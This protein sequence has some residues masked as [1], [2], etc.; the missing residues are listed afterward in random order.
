MYKSRLKQKAAFILDAKFPAKL[1]NFLFLIVTIKNQTSSYKMTSEQAKGRIRELTDKINH[2]NQQYY[3]NHIS[4]ISDYE[5]DK[6]LEELISLETQYPELKKE[7]SPTQ[8][9]GGTITKEFKQIT[10]KYPMLSL[11]NTYSEEELKDFDDRVRKA[12]GDDFE[13]TCELKFDGVAIS[14]TYENG[15]LKT[16]ATRGDGVRGDDITTNAKTIRTIPLKVNSK[17]IPSFF[18]VRGEVFLPLETFNKIN[19]DREDIGEVPL[20]NPRNAA[21]GTLK[22]QD[23]AVVARRKLDCFMYSLLGDDISAETHY[24][25]ME[26]LKEWGF[27]IS[28]TYKKSKTIEEV[29]KY[30]DF[31]EKERFK[32][33]LG[34]DGIVIKVNS[35][36]QREIL[37]FTAK[38]PRWAIAYKYKAE[39]AST[40][41]ESIEYQV[42]RTGAVT[43]VANLKPVQLAG[44]KVKRAS[45][46][47]A[48]EIERLDIRVGDTVFV[49]KGGE[50]I[51]KITAVDF[52]KRPANSEVLR[53]ITECPECGTSLVRTEGEAAYYCPNENGCPT[54]IKGRMEHFI[55]RKAMNIEGLGPETIDQLFEKGLV[56]N[57]A[58]L[59]DLTMEKLAGLERFGE[60]SAQNIIKG[61][62]KSKEVPFKNVLFAIGIRYVGS[63][64]AEKLA[65]HFKSIDYISKATYEDL[66]KAPEIGDKIALSI[67]HFFSIPANI[68]FIERLKNAGLQLSLQETELKMESEKLHGKS[69]VISGVFASFGRDEL[70]EKIEKN[71]GKVVSSISAKL[72]YLVAGENMGPAKLDKAN[73]LG[74][75]IISENDFVKMLGQ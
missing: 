69:F 53:F 46:H 9:V 63:T 38:S 14:L 51:P 7:D 71:G 70:K 64:V 19:K 17:N 41:L 34:T 61:L 12:I 44:T 31:W 62:E 73:K 30:I 29:K 75:N 20:A 43:P 3:Q 36:E 28:P 8:R 72:D 55:G 37:G 24:G 1:N 67:R 45:L 25:S 49:E 15:I 10:H 16:A 26:L 23:S 22:M 68:D 56:K 5:F 39:A 66:I 33:P 48:N 59:Y 60:K 2:Y 32:L 50:I 42:G 4:E 11:G 65:K 40:L 52:S 13:Y 54:Q 35:Y 74:I 27:H 6:L 21:S 57:P 58:D 47:N 18:E